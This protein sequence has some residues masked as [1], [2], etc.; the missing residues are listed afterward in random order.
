ME[1]EK[2]MTADHNA[3]RTS[4]RGEVL[5]PSDAGYHE[6]RKLYNAMIDKKPALIARC[7]DVADVITSVNYARDNG[8]LLAVRCGGHNGPAWAVAMTAW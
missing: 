2:N 7:V 8:I 3:F 6:A 5:E 4:M 1:G